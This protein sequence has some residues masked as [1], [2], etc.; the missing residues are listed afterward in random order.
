M[1]SSSAQYPQILCSVCDQCNAIYRCPRCAIRTCSLPCSKSHKALQSCS[2]ERDK[3]AYVPM[4][5]YDWGTMANDYA[6][7]EQV[8][9]KAAEWGLNIV[10]GGLLANGATIGRGRGRGTTSVSRSGGKGKR[11]FLKMQLDARDIDMEMLPSGMEKRKLNQS[12][13]DAK[14][15]SPLIT[16]EFV[17]HIAE[18]SLAANASSSSFTLLTHRNSL[19]ITVEDCLLRHL[20]ERGKR[21]TVPSWVKTLLSEDEDMKPIYLMAQHTCLPSNFISKTYHKLDPTQNLLSILRK[22]TF[23]EYP[24]VDIWE[25]VDFANRCVEVDGLFVETSGEPRPKKRPRLDAAGGRKIITELLA[26][27][28]SQEEQEENNVMDM[29]DNY[30]SDVESS[31]TSEQDPDFDRLDEPTEVVYRGYNVADEDVSHRRSNTLDR[32]R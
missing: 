25:D 16:I 18:N 15:K 22:K 31:Y 32:G 7:L 3:T 27:Y 10:Q 17:F 30:E 1:A 24:T 19:C 29:L 13:W 20:R 6:Y 2:G 4:N 21:G 5:K 12:T 14:L 26:G 28:A 8:G 11:D 23:V 9:R